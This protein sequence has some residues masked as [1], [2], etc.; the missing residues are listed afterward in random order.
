MEISASSNTLTIKG[1]IK[2]VSNFQDIKTNL[3]SLTREHKN[4]TI[5]LADSLSLTS[6]AIGYFNKLVLKDKI[7]MNMKIGNAKLF[8]LLSELNLTTVFNASRI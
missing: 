4:I 3:D 7:R 2:T 5:I 1:N 8:D 6:S